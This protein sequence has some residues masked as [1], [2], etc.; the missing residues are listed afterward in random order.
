MENL[1][2]SIILITHNRSSSLRRALDALQSQTYPMD[3][4]EVRVVVDSCIDDTLTMLQDYKA[5]FKMHTIE[6][7]CRSVGMSRNIGAAEAT[8]QLLLFLDDDIEAT[9][10]LVENHGRVHRERPG[11]AAIGPY[12]PKLQSRTNFFDVEVRTWWEEKFY[13]MSKPTHRYTYQDLLCGNLSIDTKL[14]A[15]TGGF[16][17]AF[18]PGTAYEDYEFALRLLKANVPF[19]VAPDAVGYHYEHE[20]NNL[21]RSFGRARAE[22]RSDVLIGQRH[23]EM[24]P[25]LHIK[26]YETPDSLVN[27]ILVAIVFFWPAALD[28][29]AVGLRKSLDWLQY[30]GMRGT[31]RWLRTKLLAY[32]YLRGVMDQLKTRSA[33]SSFMQEGTASGDLGRHE[34]EIDLQEGWEAAERIIDEKKPD[35]IYLRYGEL[36]IGHVTPKFGV[37]PL[38]GAHLR[39]ILALDFAEPLARAIAV[40]GM[41]KSAAHSEPS[42]VDNILLQ[43]LQLFTVLDKKKLENSAL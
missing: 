6:A 40:N 28:L 5:P 30:M 33:L 32:S 38:R 1:T 42:L 21:D 12:P 19:A 9:P 36:S 11:C 34:I 7:N 31:W 16:D 17:S 39:S 8:G 14:F 18:G 27:K 43:H 22:G 20:T 24:K 26:D 13:Q 37:E 29:L 23:P 35:G 4:I 10:C 25:T 15:G 41:P 2:F 3:L